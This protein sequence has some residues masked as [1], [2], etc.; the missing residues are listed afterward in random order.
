MNIRINSSGTFKLSDKSLVSQINIEAPIGLAKF[1]IQE[2]PL[3]IKGDKVNIN[4]S[5]EVSGQKDITA[6]IELPWHNISLTIFHNLLSGDGKINLHLSKSSKAEKINYKGKLKIEQLNT[7]LYKSEE[8]IVFKNGD[9]DFDQKNIQI[10]KLECRYL[11]RTYLLTGGVKNLNRPE[12]SL[13]I[14][15][16][17][18]SGKINLAY[19]QN[20]L[21]IKSVKLKLPQ[22][23]LEL[24]G[25]INDLKNLN[26][27]F[28]LSGSLHTDDLKYLPIKFN[29]RLKEINLYSLFNIEAYISGSLREWNKWKTLIKINSSET[30]IKQYKIENMDT[31]IRTKEGTLNGDLKA[32]AYN[33]ELAIDIKELSLRDNFPFMGNLIV[34]GVDLEKL[35]AVS[36]KLNKKISG[37]FHGEFTCRGEIKKIK[38]IKGEGWFE[39]TDGLLWELPV[40][41]KLSQIIEIPGIEKNVFR[42][43]HANFV[44]NNQTITTKD[45]ELISKRLT[46]KTQ[47]SIYFNG[48][49]DLRVR[50]EFPPETQP[51]SS[52]ALD[53]L[54]DILLKGA[55]ALF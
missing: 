51:S 25:L 33:G 24:Q 11:E 36:L 3:E 20:S 5:L 21:D 35:N 55:G 7:S 18:I 34:E 37:S 17:T 46:L 1:F 54:Q 31:E 22:S 14:S 43:A 16:E 49:L 45:L 4:V 9:I 15:S 6:D 10:N 13:D 41:D 2:I 40:F 38:E 30:K 53:K 48:N 26:G 52:E 29:S 23:K 28:Y 44:V 27:E 42:E 19:L 47:G 8:K 50:M 39:I 32:N 12:I